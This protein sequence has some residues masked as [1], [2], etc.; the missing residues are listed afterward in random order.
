MTEIKSITGN[1][2]YST[3]YKDN[4][5]E[6]YSKFYSGLHDRYKHDE[7][8]DLLFIPDMSDII[9]YDKLNPQHPLEFCK[10]VHKVEKEKDDAE[11]QHF[12]NLFLYDKKI[13]EKEINYWRT[14]YRIREIERQ[15]IWNKSKELKIEL[16]EEKKNLE[17]YNNNETGKQNENTEEATVI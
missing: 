11:L 5:L 8:L 17:L 7:Y 2:L 10:N 9:K 6:A 15:M 13:N 12:E 1:N 3:E 16:E 4:L 14:Y